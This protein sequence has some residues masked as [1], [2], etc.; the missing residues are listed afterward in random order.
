MNYIRLGEKIKKIRANKNK[1]QEEFA[2]EI[3][4][5]PSYLGQIERGQKKVA[6]KT[7]DKI[8][9]KFDV[10]IGNLICDMN[11]DNALFRYWELITKDLT[12]EDKEELANAFQALLT[13]INHINR[14]N[15]IE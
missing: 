8:S 15:K 9:K 14:R 4:I 10:P 13:T 2:E 6:L 1:S 11:I 5:S 3:G 12:E 7:L